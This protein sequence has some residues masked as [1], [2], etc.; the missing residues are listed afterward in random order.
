MKY[1]ISSE[2]LL[3]IYE[4]KKWLGEI[5]CFIDD[6]DDDDFDNGVFKGNQSVD[7]IPLY[8]NKISDLNKKIESLELLLED[9]NKENDKK[10]K[11]LEELLKYKDV[12]CDMIKTINDFKTKKKNINKRV[13]KGKKNLEYIKSLKYYG[14]RVMFNKNSIY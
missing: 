14:F 5:D 12:E 2:E 6:N 3:K 13:K 7:L 9:R 11:K 1:V 8:N 4:K 10:I